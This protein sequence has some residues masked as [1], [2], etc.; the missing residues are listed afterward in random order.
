MFGS[1]TFSR[2]LAAGLTLAAAMVAGGAQAA[3]HTLTLSGSAF[4][5][6]TNTFTFDGVTYETGALELTGFTPFILADGD[7]IEAT[8]NITSGPLFPFIVPSRDQMF[9][10]LNFSDISGG[11]Q[12]ITSTANGTFAFD[13]GG[14]VNAGCGNCT[15]LIYGQNGGT[16]FFTNLAA[17]GSF[18]MDSPYEINSITVSYQV[19]NT[20][21]AAVPEPA[22]WAL[23]ITGFG[24]AGVMLRRSRRSFARTSGLATGAAA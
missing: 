2:A 8:V 21:V 3:T 24:G 12:P 20:G 4:D 15:S 18:T 10:G 11:A 22:S 13:G 5:I 9:F 17:S 23:M 1:K 6:T 16:L 19:N 7:T 14:P